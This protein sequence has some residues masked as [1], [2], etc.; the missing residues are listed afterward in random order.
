[1]GVNDK[2]HINVTTDSVEQCTSPVGEC[3]FADYD[4]HFW[5]YGEACRAHERTQ[6][7]FADAVAR[8]SRALEPGW[9]VEHVFDPQHPQT[10]SNF[11]WLDDRTR[12]IAA[13]T[14][15]VVENG[16][17]FTKLG[18]GNFWELTEGDGDAGGVR[19]GLPLTVYQCPPSLENFGGRMEYGPG[20]APIRINWR[21]ARDESGAA[22]PGNNTS[23]AR[24]PLGE[25]LPY[26]VGA[27][28]A[29]YCMFRG[30]TECSVG[31]PHFASEEQ[32]KRAHAFAIGPVTL[33]GKLFQ[34]RRVLDPHVA[35]LEAIEQR[36]VAIADDLNQRDLR[37]R[38]A[39]LAQQARTEFGSSGELS[40]DVPVTEGEVAARTVPVPGQDAV[41]GLRYGQHNLSAEDFALEKMSESLRL[42][43]HAAGDVLFH[44]RDGVAVFAVKGIETLLFGDG[45]EFDPAVEGERAA[46]QRFTG[47]AIAEFTGEKALVIL[48]A[49]PR[50]AWLCH[51]LAEA[52]AA[53]HL[54]MANPANP[55]DPLAFFFDE[56]DLS[57]DTK[58]EQ[59]RQEVTRD[60]ALAY[61]AETRHGLR[62]LRGTLRRLAPDVSY[63]V[64]DIRDV[65]FFLDLSLAGRKPIVGYF[66]KDELDRFTRHDFSSLR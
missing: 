56:R 59:V 16:W 1:M 45:H 51:R 46:R 19:R 52:H 26:H 49:D 32:A 38:G 42:G 14:R 64:E 11:G 21:V 48:T 57:A 9:R 47:N 25:D 13:G 30:G 5:N 3:E 2:F 4:D 65:R 54:R 34:R 37:S 17:V 44:E 20:V 63:P 43:A 39:T 31:G 33:P 50:E 10:Y 61:I 29:E 35:H 36:L 8:S 41:L 7:F 53:G 58:R 28:G 66:T 22:T 15:L 62:G 12:P 60:F 55:F 23:R 40:V 27:N 18:Y 6:A 24:G